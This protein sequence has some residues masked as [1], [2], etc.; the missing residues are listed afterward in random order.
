VLAARHEPRLRPPGRRPAPRRSAPRCPQQRR[1]AR[2]SPQRCARRRPTRRCLARLAGPRLC[3]CWPPPRA[4]RPPGRRPAPRRAALGSGASPAARRSAAPAAA[5]R[6]GASLA[7]PARASAG[8]GRPPRAP[9][10]PLGRH[11]AQPGSVDH[12]PC[13]RPQRSRSQSLAAS[14]HLAVCAPVVWLPAAHRSARA[15]GRAC[16]AGDAAR[17]HTQCFVCTVSVSNF[18]NKKGST[19]AAM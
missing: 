17:R 3:G 15:C 14:R 18:R 11:L 8:A 10:G 16:E 7:S 19:L 5:L 13:R 12:F 2:R 6:G 1:L 9:P 4:P